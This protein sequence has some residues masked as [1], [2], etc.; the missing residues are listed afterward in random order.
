MCVCVCVCVCM[1]VRVCVH[2]R[3][4]RILPRIYGLLCAL[5][6]SSDGRVR[7]ALAHLFVQR[8]GPSLEL[9]VSP[10]NASSRPLSSAPSPHQG[11]NGTLHQ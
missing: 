5:I 2:Q 1:C 10:S 6:E 8:I 7:S 4:V 9:S 11:S 3:L